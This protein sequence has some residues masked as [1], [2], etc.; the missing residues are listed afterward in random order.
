MP[1]CSHAFDVIVLGAGAAGLMGAATAGQR[2]LLRGSAP[3]R[4]GRRHEPVEKRKTSTRCR[5]V[6]QMLEI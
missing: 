3:G 6:A 4:S 5:L 1:G 2:E